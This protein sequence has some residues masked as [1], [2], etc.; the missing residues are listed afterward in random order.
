MG[1]SF[2]QKRVIIPEF[3]SSCQSY[4]PGELNDIFVIFYLLSLVVLEQ[5]METLT[6][7]T[8]LNRLPPFLW[9]KSPT[10]FGKIH[11]GPPIKIH[12]NLSKSLPRMN[13]YPVSKEALQGIKPVIEDYEA[14]AL[15]FFVPDPVTLP[16]YQ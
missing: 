6:I 4:Q 5:I 13:Q 8:Y 10:G 7:C 1:I 12:I 2:S 15:L 16:F 9:A 14:Q 3:D 11:C